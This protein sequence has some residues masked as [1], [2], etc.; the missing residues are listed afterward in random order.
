MEADIRVVKE[1]LVDAEKSRQAFFESTT[2]KQLL[3]AQ[4]KLQRSQKQL[5]DK[6][7]KLLADVSLMDADAIDPEWASSQHKLSGAL[8]VVNNLVGLL[9]L[10]F[11]LSNTA[12]VSEEALTQFGMAIDALPNNTAPFMIVASKATADCAFELSKIGT[13]SAAHAY[14]FLTPLVSHPQFQHD[15]VEVAYDKVVGKHLGL[16]LAASKDDYAASVEAFNA[17]VGPLPSCMHADLCE[18]TQ[19]LD[20][21]LRTVT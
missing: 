10:H 21:N 8:D 13:G 17:S 11:Q 20:R 18:Q 19:H 14:D 1:M 2:K 15:V 9:T 3:D 7:G 6:Q 5:T 16:V 4:S 12:F